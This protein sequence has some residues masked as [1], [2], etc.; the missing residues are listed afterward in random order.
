MTVHGRRTAATSASGGA[1]A[2][3]RVKAQSSAQNAK[4]A[5]NA[6]SASRRRRAGQRLARN[7][8]YASSREGSLIEAARTRTAG[9]S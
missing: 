5:G 6:Y 2:S 9:E 3:D 8:R 1:A 7:C 4:L